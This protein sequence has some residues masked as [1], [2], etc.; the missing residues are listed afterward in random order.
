MNTNNHVLIR[1]AKSVV[2]VLTVVIA[3]FVFNEAKANSLTDQVR[4]EAI[5]IGDASGSHTIS[6]LRDYTHNDPKVIDALVK[7]ATKDYKIEH[8]DALV[9]VLVNKSRPQHFSKVINNSFDITN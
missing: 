3:A 7:Q 2:I 9:T 8:K 1:I 6:V 5:G 4:N